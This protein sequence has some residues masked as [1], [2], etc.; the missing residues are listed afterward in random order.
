MTVTEQACSDHRLPE[1]VTWDSLAL[2]RAIHA[3]K[4]SCR[5]VMA[6]YLDHVEACNARGNAIRR[7]ASVRVTARKT[8]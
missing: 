3:C 6:A 8:G 5:E 1:P 7:R 4:I 2:S